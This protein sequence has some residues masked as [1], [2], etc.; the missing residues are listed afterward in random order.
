MEQRK[1]VQA[2]GK[3]AFTDLSSEPTWDFRKVFQASAV[4]YVQLGEEA[5]RYMQSLQFKLFLNL[6]LFS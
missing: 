3:K 1:R 2:A 4:T 6:I 5:R